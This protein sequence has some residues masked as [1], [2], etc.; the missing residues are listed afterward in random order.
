MKNKNL[1]YLLGLV[2]AVVWGI[3]IYRI[4]DAAKGNDDDMAIV[5][6]TIK[7]EAY[8]DFAVPKDTVHLL[9]NYRDP[10]GVTKQKDTAVLPAKNIV[11]R[12]NPIVPKPAF[13]WNFI[14]YSG[15]VRNPSSKKLIT[16][17]SING[18]NEMFSEGDVKDQVKLIKNMRDSI[19]ISYN[20]KL[21]YI[22]I[23]PATL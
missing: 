6:T 16:L 22:T 20:G 12:I 7:K 13:N 3:I 2:V 10:F 19:K 11:H 17:M 21:K 14:Q 4:F 18:K 9:L 23:K 8:N 5:H 15:Y 1:T